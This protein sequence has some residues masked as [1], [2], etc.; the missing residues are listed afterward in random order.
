[1]N[2]S[3]TKNKCMPKV[4]VIVTTY[5]RKDYLTETI[6]S[7]LKQTYQDFELIVVDN[8]SNYD[9]FALIE[10][11]KN[12]KIIAFQNQN[13]GIIAVNRNVGISHAKGEYIA[14]C[15]DDD[16]WLN[17]KLEK[18]ILVIESQKVDL[19]YSNIYCFDDF[20]KEYKRKVKQI[21]NIK[22]LLKKNEISLSTVLL[23]NNDI[24]KFDEDVNVLS[25]EDYLLWIDLYLNGF[26]FGYLDEYSIKYRISS[27]S[28]FSKQLNIIYLKL[29]YG[30]TKVMI[31]MNGPKNL[32]PIFSYITILNTIKLII[33]QMVFRPKE[34]K[35]K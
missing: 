31:K 34:H 6:Q 5:N 9:F 18:Q 20:E 22:Q 14:F 29:N 30:I 27:T 11:F 8:Y 2:Q 26:K 25:I 17:D 35:D 13:N 7:I 21:K 10:S 24:V 19:V 3:R 28:V 16:I 4:S 33:K 15:D 32:T 23:R 1:M 12:N